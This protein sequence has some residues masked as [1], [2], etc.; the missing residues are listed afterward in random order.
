MSEWMGPRRV[1]VGS[2]LVLLRVDAALA[3][4]CPAGWTRQGLKRGADALLTDKGQW[5]ENR[6]KL[7]SFLTLEILCIFSL[8]SAGGMCRIAFLYV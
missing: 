1:G 4:R 5:I 6:K 3:V 7:S 2:P 8:S